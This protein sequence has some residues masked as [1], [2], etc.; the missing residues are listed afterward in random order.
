MEINLMSDTVTRPTLERPGKNALVVALG[1]SWSLKGDALGMTG[2]IRT[3]S[4]VA[5]RPLA[6]AD[7]LLERER[8]LGTL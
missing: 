4:P 1:G 2:L 3:Q 6:L 5:V 8:E 7:S